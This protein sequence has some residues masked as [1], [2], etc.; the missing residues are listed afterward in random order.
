MR[1]AV[2][3]NFAFGNK[4]LK[5]LTSRNFIIFLILGIGA[6][7]RLYNISGKA[8]WYDEACSLS[9]TG[10]GW[11]DILTH[12]YMTRPVYFIILKLWVG[13]FGS[14]EFVA[15]LPSAIFGIVSIIIIYKIAK[16]LFNQNVGMLS[17]FFFS[18]SPFQ[19]YY[20]RELRNYSLF[21]LLALLSMFV[22][23]KILD[24][25]RAILYSLYV[26]INILLVYTHP[27]GVYIIL[28]QTTYLL[29]LFKKV[30]LDSRWIMAQIILILFSLLFLFWLSGRFGHVVNNELDYITV[31]N[32]RSLLE[33][34]EVFSYGGY[35]QGHGGVGFRVSDSR[36]LIPRILTVFLCCLLIFG[37]LGNKKNDRPKLDS[38]SHL[39]KRL[40]LFLWLF[41][42]IGATY[43]YSRLVTPI[44]LNRYLLAASAA[45]YIIVARG[46]ML[47]P[48]MRYRI[49]AMAL[50]TVLT[51]Y[52]LGLL[53][54]P[55]S[56]EDWR[57]VAHY[58]KA[59]I[60]QG[61]SIILVPIMQIV[62]FWYY[63]EY[64]K[65][66]NLSGIDK[67]GRQ[68]EGEWRTEFIENGHLV[69][70]FSVGNDQDMI[71]GKI[72]NLKNIKHDIWLIIS[73]YWVKADFYN[74]ITGLLRK[75][76]FLKHAKYFSYDGVEVAVYS[77]K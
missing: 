4:L 42:P 15:R 17:A 34:A 68:V 24:R 45:F 49:S 16:L 67:C 59:N 72:D 1:L 52:S 64:G 29:V 12:R 66:E 71:A 46:I 14:G 63:F 38:L 55:G 41:I 25:G 69:L 65:A 36:L 62:P 5:V 28:A 77:I 51:V 50:A 10:Y 39:D 26:M 30:K 8:L 54:N 20:S 37:L 7:L 70:G 27:F 2:T 61:D 33:T 19:I 11:Q 47:L 40:F 48:R 3:E 56:S 13:L 35:I 76:F 21:L 32:F 73:P 44:Y 75:H 31:P 74:L 57:K 53:Y 43:L 9:F 6:F 58:V 22:F 18:I 60:N 23:I